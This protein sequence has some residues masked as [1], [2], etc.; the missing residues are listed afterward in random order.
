MGPAKT[1]K[2][3]GE[4]EEKKLEEKTSTVGGGQNAMQFLGIKPDQDD[5]VLENNA[6]I[7]QIEG[8]INCGVIPKY[9]QRGEVAELRSDKHYVLINLLK[10]EK[11][12]APEHVATVNTFVTIEWG[13]QTKRTATI[14][15]SYQPVYNQLFAFKIPVKK[16]LEKDKKALIKFLKSELEPNNYVVFDLW[17]EGEGGGNDNLGSYT[18]PLAELQNANREERT[19]RDSKTKKN[20]KY[21]SKVLEVNRKL[22]SGEDESGTGQILFEIWFLPDLEEIN[23]AEFSKIKGDRIPPELSSTSEEQR[24]K[25]WIEGISKSFEKTPSKVRLRNF[26][27]V[28]V[29]DQY[30]KRHLISMYL[31]KFT[32]NKCISLTFMHFF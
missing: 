14:Y 4:D 7:V 9:R 20:I 3:N 17:L 23:L 31:S 15:D 29:K 18:F 19:Y 21:I 25:E 6:I 30:A 27:T 10:V 28:Y 13:G 26:N 5:S 16:G 32:M 11:I 12:Q 24:S 1:L 2:K 8:R 22:V